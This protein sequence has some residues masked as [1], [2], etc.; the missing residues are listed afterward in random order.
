M[1]LELQD[2]GLGR[3][4]SG[5]SWESNRESTGLKGA[6]CAPPAMATEPSDDPEMEP[7]ALRSGGVGA[8]DRQAG[9]ETCKAQAPAL[10]IRV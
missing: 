9:M 10:L 2:Q 4:R 5:V 3:S 1:P 7:P 8:W 6:M